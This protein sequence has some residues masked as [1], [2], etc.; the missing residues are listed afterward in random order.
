MVNRSVAHAE[1]Q[2]QSLGLETKAARRKWNPSLHPRD[3]KGR[4]IETGGTVRLWGGKLARVVRALPND[5]ILVQ[6]RGDGGEFNG[7]RHTTSAKW[8][9]MVARPDGSAPTGDEKKVVAEDERR[10]EDPKQGN[11]VVRDDDGDPTT[12]NEPHNADDP[13]RDR[14]KWRTFFGNDFW[15]ARPLRRGHDDLGYPQ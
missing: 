15:A 6:D 9:T 12:P 11:G 13:P 2:E 8:V 3:S 14:R 1:S 4:F 7:R 5:R 10:H